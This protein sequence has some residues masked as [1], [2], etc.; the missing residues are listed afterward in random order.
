MKCSILSSMW[1]RTLALGLCAVSMSGCS[2]LSGGQQ[3]AI[4]GGGLGAIAGQVLGGST[5]ATLIGAGI[6]SG[7]GYVIGN[8]K[9]KQAAKDLSRDNQVEGTH[10]EVGSLGGTQWTV[11]SIVPE[12]AFAPA[13][14]RLIDFHPY[15]RLTST[16]VN[17][18][19]SIELFDESYRVVGK[20]LIVNR[21]GYI[22]NATFDISGDRLRI[23][24]GDFEATLHRR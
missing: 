17:M 16:R 22:I 14:S 23:H 15:G 24:A 19:D 3:S 4:I 9:D 18:D 8:E 2:N 13:K 20:T 5:E 21:K 11:S 10:N 6:G 7:V 12:D 1:T